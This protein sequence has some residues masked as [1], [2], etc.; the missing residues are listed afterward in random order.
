MAEQLTIGPGTTLTVL[1]RTEEELVLEARYEGGG[2]P[3]PSHLHPAQ[4]EHFEIL[5]GAMLA[6]I[7]GEEVE[8]RAGGE[9]EVP[10]GTAHKMWNAG[11]EVAVT[12]WVTSPAGRTLDWFREIAAALSGEP[13]GDPAT[14]LD[15]Y[16][17]VFRLVEE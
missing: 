8:A 13:I 9:L 7:G 14:M 6:Q 17:D 11:E 16:G 5:Q 2:S 15:R 10:R 3:P 4:D 1:S 12:R